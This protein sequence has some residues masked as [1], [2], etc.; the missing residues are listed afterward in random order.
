MTILMKDKLTNPNALSWWLK[1]REKNTVEE[2]FMGDIIP[3]F[4][5]TKVYGRKFVTRSFSTSRDISPNQR[6]AAVNDFLKANPEYGV[7]AV[8]GGTVHLAKNSDKGVAVKEEI[9][10]LDPLAEGTETNLDL[11][12][13]ELYLQQFDYDDPTDEE[14]REYTEKLTEHASE[15]DLEY[16][17]EQ[18]VTF[19][20]MLTEMNTAASTLKPS[21][22]PDVPYYNRLVL[23]ETETSMTV[24]IFVNPEYIDA[25]KDVYTDYDYAKSPVYL[26]KIDFMYPQ[27]TYNGNRFDLTMEQVLMICDNLSL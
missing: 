22:T 13:L 6:D 21:I 17:S 24:L 1:T 27:E 15:E 4:S 10:R 8:T 20:E 18:I 16:I 2:G 3:S 26:R 14:L 23:D 7:I 12:A 9:E 25:Q 5:T 11:I 19:G